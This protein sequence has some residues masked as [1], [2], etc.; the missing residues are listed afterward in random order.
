M[1]MTPGV[2]F[3]YGGMVNKKNLLSTIA[4][5]LLV[6]CIAS[7]TWGLVGFSLAFGNTTGANGYI[8][9]C[10]Y[11][12]LRNISLTVYTEYAGTIPLASFFF[13]QT[14]FAAITPAIFIGSIIGRIRVPFLIVL[15]VAFNIIVYS[16]IAYWVWNHQGWLYKMGALDFAG[17]DVIHIPAGFAGLAS[18]V[19]LGH[20]EG[21]HKPQKQNSASI[22]LTLIGTGILWVGWFGFNGGS[23]LASGQLAAVA[24]TNSHLAACAAG[25]GW[26]AVQYLVTRQPSIVGWCC[27]AICGLVAITPAAGFVSLWSS[28]IIGMLGGVFSYL[29]CH[30]KS[31]YFEELTDTLD[32]FGCHGISAIW[33]GIA[34]GLFAT[35][36]SSNVNTG[37]FYGNGRQLGVNILAI[38]VCSAYSFFMTWLI[39]FLLGKVME[40]KVSEEEELEGLDYAVH[41]EEND[42]LTEK[43]IINI[44]KSANNIGSVGNILLN[45]LDSQHSIKAI[46][47]DNKK[48]ENTDQVEGN[49]IVL[50]VMHSKTNLIP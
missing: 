1:F 7:V 21:S 50:E 25:L 40:A 33:G 35:T 11:C 10:V 31:K 19:Y 45:R 17:G 27:G 41:G 46:K 26:A 44:L 34:T 29:F 43:D 13:F 39:Y 3:F 20:G 12:G 36:D 42:P 24:I 22:S 23:A 30:F 15:T 9:D 8:G 38:V 18:A 47:E 4:Y 48:S 37:A 28:L 16:P 6:F 49:E 32:V 5:C 2:G 14:M